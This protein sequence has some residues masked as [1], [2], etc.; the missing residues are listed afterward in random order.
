MRLNSNIIHIS[1]GYFVVEKWLLG[2]QFMNFIKKK[3]LKVL[4]RNC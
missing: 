1:G 2:K 3:V 4:P